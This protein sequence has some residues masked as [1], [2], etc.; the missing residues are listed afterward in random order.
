MSTEFEEMGPRKKEFLEV[1]LI[2]Q[3]RSWTGMGSTQD[4]NS[5]RKPASVTQNSPLIFLS[6]AS[7]VTAQLRCSLVLE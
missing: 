5:L 4:W 3:W 2:L 1:L 6:C 7:Q